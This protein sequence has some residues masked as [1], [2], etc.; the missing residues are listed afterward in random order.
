M[1]QSVLANREMHLDTLG[2]YSPSSKIQVSSYDLRNLLTSQTLP[3]QTEFVSAEWVHQKDLC[4]AAVGDKSYLF[5][6]DARGNAGMDKHSLHFIETRW[7]DKDAP[8][9]ISASDDPIIS[10]SYEYVQHPSLACNDEELG[11]LAVWLHGSSISADI[12]AQYLGLDGSMEFPLPW[13]ITSTATATADARP[14]VQVHN[15]NF[16]IF[17]RDPAAIMKFNDYGS[18]TTPLITLSDNPTLL[19]DV[20]PSSSDADIL[21]IKELKGADVSMNLYVEKCWESG[22]SCLEYN[23]TEYPDG[24]V[25]II[26]AEVAVVEGA[27]N[28]YVVAWLERQVGIETRLKLAYLDTY[29]SPA[30]GYP[31]TLKQWDGSGVGTTVT[32]FSMAANSNYVEILVPSI[33][34]DYYAEF[35]LHGYPHPVDPASLANNTDILRHRYYQGFSVTSPYLFRIST[36]TEAALITPGQKRDPAEVQ[37]GNG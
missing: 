34:Y 30:A 22:G 3:E 31:V 27:E 14:V 6:D 10:H 11:C 25:E 20:A 5:W 18:I 23:I 1:R 12:W 33:T 4:I 13:P 16:E 28:P 7:L 24:M 19:F 15:N 9:N 35:A 37:E 2:G 36:G 32:S 26:S 21:L 8:Y 29:L 17:W